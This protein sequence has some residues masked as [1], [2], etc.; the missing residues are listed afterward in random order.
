M[1]RMNI[2]LLKGNRISLFLEEEEREERKKT[3]NVIPKK[4]DLLFN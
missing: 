4:N 3:E 2:L 1:I